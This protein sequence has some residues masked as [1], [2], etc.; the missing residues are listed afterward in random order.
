MYLHL[1]KFEHPINSPYF[2]LRLTSSP[3]HLGILYH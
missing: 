3:P 1:G 2:P